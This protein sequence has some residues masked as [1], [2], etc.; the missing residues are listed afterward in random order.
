MD[1][2]TVTQF[3]AADKLG[4]MVAEGQIGPDEAQLTL[5]LVVERAKQNAPDVAPHGLRTR[6]V[7]AMRDAAT[8]TYLER[9]RRERALERQL[10]ALAAEGYA[11]RAPQAL[12]E[13]MIGK[14][15]LEIGANPNSIAPAIRRGEWLVRNGQW[16][17]K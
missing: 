2:R 17:K 1:N 5:D 7:W 9:I 6:L 3:R 15:A 11:R 12:I 8:A 16:T 10:A 13:R 4:E 14:T